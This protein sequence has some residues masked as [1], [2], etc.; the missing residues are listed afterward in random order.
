MRPALPDPPSLPTVASVMRCDLET[1]H[2]DDL[3]ASAVRRMLD[4][5]IHAVPVVESDG[6]V[7][8]LFSSTDL[9]WHADE[10]TAT[11]LRRREGPR[12]PPLGARPV[13]DLMTP[14]LFSVPPDAP[15]DDLLRFFAKRGLHRALVLEGGR[16]VGLVSLTD[17]LPLVA[18]PS[19]PR[20]E[21]TDIH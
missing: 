17:L 11:A 4:H 6:R 3:V 8:G 21:P 10:F 9:M 16:L 7:V 19:P 2:P 15:L 14:D 12:Q 13:R 18:G 1:V 5:G 20:P